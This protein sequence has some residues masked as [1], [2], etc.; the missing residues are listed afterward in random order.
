MNK[1]DIYLNKLEIIGDISDLD[2][3]Q[4]EFY[5]YDILLTQELYNN[6]KEE[7]NN[8]NNKEEDNNNNLLSFIVSVI[9][10]ELVNDVLDLSKSDIKIFKDKINK[11]LEIICNNEIKEEINKVNEILN[12]IISDGYDLNSYLMSK[13]IELYDITKLSDKD[14]DIIMNEKIDSKT[15]VDRIR[16]NINKLFDKIKNDITLLLTGEITLEMFKTRNKINNDINVFNSNRLINDQISR[17]SNIAKMKWFNDNNIKE[18]MYN[19]VLCPTTCE[20]CEELHGKIFNINDNMITLPL[21]INCYCFWTPVIN[22]WN[23][24]NT[25]I[26]WKDFRSWKEKYNRIGGDK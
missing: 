20:M 7:I 11:K 5:N 25:V 24:N 23:N 12:S 6:Q 17:K 4:L 10:G 2:N 9:S 26:S 3:N 22:E 21:H 14:L 1:K 13:G 8:I 16:N 19:S 18:K 15:H